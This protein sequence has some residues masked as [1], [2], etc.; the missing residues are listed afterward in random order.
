M[1]KVKKGYFTI[2]KIGW[3]KALSIGNSYKT[4][5]VCSLFVGIQY[6]QITKPLLNLVCVVS[7]RSGTLAP[8][9]RLSDSGEDA[10]EKER[11]RHAKSWRGQFP[12]VLAFSIQWTRL[13]RSLE[14][15]TT[16]GARDF[17]SAVSGFCQVKMCRPSANTENSRRTRKK[18]LVPRIQMWVTKVKKNYFTIQKSGWAKPKVPPPPPPPRGP[19]VDNSSI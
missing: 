18:P 19:C 8:C 1:T 6:F 17:F 16:L 14:Q 15:A 3:A 12:P 7:D 9:S 10:K 4:K 13:S 2:R 5:F 11:K